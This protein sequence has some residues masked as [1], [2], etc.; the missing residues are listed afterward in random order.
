[1]KM[2]FK[3]RSQMR[4]FKTNQKKVDLGTKSP[5]RWAVEIVR[6]TKNNGIVEFN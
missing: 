3:T 6:P 5:K 4:A 1:M 2:Y